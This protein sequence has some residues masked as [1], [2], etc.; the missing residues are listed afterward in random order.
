MQQKVFDNI[1]VNGD[2]LLHFPDIGYLTL[3]VKRQP[4]VDQAVNYDMYHY[5]TFSAAIMKELTLSEMNYWFVLHHHPL[6]L[7]IKL[8][9][10]NT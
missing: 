7:R 9:Q 5:N 4:V 2:I 1:A 8:Q 3:Y 6:D 10:T